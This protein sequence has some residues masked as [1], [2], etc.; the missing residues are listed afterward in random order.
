MRELNEKNL[1]S[2]GK[3]G[4]ELGIM[5]FN[6]NVHFKS[7]LFKFPFHPPES[8]TQYNNI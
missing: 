7:F 3:S 6:W 1:S 8:N 2:V 5:D 4:N